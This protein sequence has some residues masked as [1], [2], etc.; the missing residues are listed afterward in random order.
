M[1]VKWVTVDDTSV[2]AGAVALILCALAGLHPYWAVGGSQG[3][4]AAV[5]EREGKPLFNPSPA[6]CLTAND[7]EFEFLAGILGNQRALELPFRCVVATLLMS[8]VEEL[9]IRHVIGV[10]DCVAHL[11]LEPIVRV[12]A[13]ETIAVLGDTN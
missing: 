4:K 1:F 5:P 13:A 7:I 9:L 2:I 8:R 6:A 11:A 10:V 12:A 3:A